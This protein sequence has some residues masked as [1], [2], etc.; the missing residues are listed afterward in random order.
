MLVNT[1]NDLRPFYPPPS[2]WPKKNP[3]KPKLTR[4]DHNKVFAGLI[5]N[6]CTHYL[7]HDNPVAASVMVQQFGCGL[8]RYS[9][10][11]NRISDC[12]LR[13][14]TSESETEKQPKPSL[15][16]WSRTVA[17]CWRR[18]AIDGP[19]LREPPL[20]GDGLQK[21]DEVDKPAQTTPLIISEKT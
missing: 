12:L 6:S 8:Q 7:L 20:S 2:P 19:G 17:N 18:D 10:S 13:Q 1:S 4:N 16:G 14:R 5:I 3:S 21:N 15:T 9:V 11:Q